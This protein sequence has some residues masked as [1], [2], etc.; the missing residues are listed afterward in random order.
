MSSSS[1]GVSGGGFKGS[2]VGGF[3]E[4]RAG[5]KLSPLQPLP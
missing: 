4:F 1:Q 2:G 5:V 3:M